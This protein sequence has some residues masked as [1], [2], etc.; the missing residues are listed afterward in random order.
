MGLVFDILSSINNPQQQG[1]VDQLST[2]LG[3]VSK[4]AATQGL[5][6]NGT[7]SLLSNVEALSVP[8]SRIRRLQLVQGT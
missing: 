1:S 8:S 4:L 7:Q 5:D 2:L 6:A 3:G